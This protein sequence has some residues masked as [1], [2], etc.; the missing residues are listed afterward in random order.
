MIKQRCPEAD[1]EIFIEIAPEAIVNAAL[2]HDVTV[3]P[4]NPDVVSSYRKIHDHKRENLFGLVE[5]SSC[6]SL[7]SDKVRCVR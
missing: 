5:G 6:S 2:E 3:C 1:I 4:I 7:P